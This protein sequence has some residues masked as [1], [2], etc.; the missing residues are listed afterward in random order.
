MSFLREK[1]NY[2]KIL[3]NSLLE[4]APG[5]EKF[6]A[7]EII[8]FLE[9]TNFALFRIDAPGRLFYV[10]QNW[11]NIT[12]YCI[13]ESLNKH[14]YNYIHPDDLTDYKHFYFNNTRQFPDTSHITIRIIC[15]DDTYKWV[16]I[17][18]KAEPEKDKAE[19]VYKT[20]LLVDVNDDVTNAHQLNVQ[21]KSLDKLIEN[22]PG[23]IYRCLNNT[24]W[25]MEFISAG[26]YEITGYQPEEIT[27]NNKLSYAAL[28]LPED[29][30][31]VWNEVQCALDERRTFELVYRIK[32]ANGQEKW[33]WEQGHGVFSS[34]GELLV[35]EGYITD[36]TQDK[37]A[38]EEIRKGMLYD[39]ATNCPNWLVFND[40]LLSAT[41]RKKHDSRYAFLFIL[42]QIDKFED[43]RN[44]YGE[45]ISK[46]AVIEIQKKIKNSLRY[47]GVISRANDDT[48][49][50]LLESIDEFNNLNK[51][52]QSIH[53][54]VL[55]PVQVDEFE[56]YTSA[57]LGIALSTKQYENS[58]EVIYDAEQA[59]SRARALGGARHEVFDLRQHAKAAAQY[60]YEREICDA[61]DN[62][63]MKVCWQPV[64]S[65]KSNTIAGLEAK[66]TWNHAQRNTL[67]A[68]DFV[69]QITDN[70]LLL[71]LW[72]FMLK[73]AC[74][75]MNQWKS[76]PEFNELGINL[77]IFGESLLAA[78]SILRL[79]ERL[80]ESKP[81]SCS[82]SLGVPEE[83]FLRASD[84][85]KEMLD[86]LQS[87][88]ISIILDSFGEGVCALATLKRYPL[89]MIRLHPLL[90]NR[91]H[92]DP[93]FVKS[94][95]SLVH[96]FDI[97]VIADRLSNHAQLRAAIEYDV[98]YVQGSIISEA[99]HP[100]DVPAAINMNFLKIPTS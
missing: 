38:D 93:R 82:I 64:I 26:C 13:E 44:I 47:T 12:G 32:T 65:L 22:V 20:G 1:T 52:I 95:V 66:L 83:V 72:E 59:L 67:F 43:I 77:H 14:H 10:S 74:H 41:Q 28:I 18:L 40:R 50:I 51:I 60:K 84:T 5:E 58:N 17:F 88:D 99:L 25:T 30:Q 37:E 71:Q 55:L 2:L 81:S 21:L 15:K 61:M 90:L 100:E 54:I 23:M 34:S 94:V 35:V 89:D 29:Q 98:D 92:C 68:E 75:N 31:Y 97:P 73:D 63:A 49:G 87:R 46:R 80:L 56:I 62:K 9:D 16:R 6:S 4:E 76:M 27:K 39:E 3:I 86:W 11:E 42:L 69:P 48:L 24:K 79:G 91:Q 85:V 96:S 7:D 53:E 36:I 70:Q 78:D 19:S 57:S 33:V 8:S 45:E